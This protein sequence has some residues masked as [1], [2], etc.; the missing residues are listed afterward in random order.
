MKSGQSFKKRV[1]FNYIKRPGI[2]AVH[3]DADAAE[4]CDEDPVKPDT[5]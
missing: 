3:D 2:C 5:Y 1:A 4:N